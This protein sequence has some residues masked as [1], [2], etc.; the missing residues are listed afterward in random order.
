MPLSIQK[1][2]SPSW[3]HSWESSITESVLAQIAA[4][5][6]SIM[7]GDQK[8]DIRT[9]LE[10]VFHAKSQAVADIIWTYV[11]GDTI[12]LKCNPN[13][14]TTVLISLHERTESRWKIIVQVTCTQKNSTWSRNNKQRSNKIFLDTM[15]RVREFKKRIRETGTLIIQYL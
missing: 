15:N 10:R 4:E 13:D 3:I 11:P 14:Y 7:G 8:G 5:F 9:P 12:V 6:E 1:Q 2:E